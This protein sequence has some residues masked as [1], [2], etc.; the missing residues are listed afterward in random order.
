MINLNDSLL[1]PIDPEPEF[2]ASDRTCQRQLQRLHQVA[3]YSR[4]FLVGLLWISVA[5]WSLW[6]LRSEFALWRDYFTWT[7]V[8]YGLAFNLVPTVGLT[9]CIALTVSTLIWQSRNI[10]FGLPKRQ[11]KQLK[12]RLLKIRQQGESHPLWLWVCGELA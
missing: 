11:R 2:R 5:P 4:W 6:S 12:Q 9:L 1:P 7:A 3:V 8:R 10:L